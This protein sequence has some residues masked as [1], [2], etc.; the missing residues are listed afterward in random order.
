MGK[1]IRIIRYVNSPF[2]FNLLPFHLQSQHYK[3]RGHPS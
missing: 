3:E 2:L 1:F